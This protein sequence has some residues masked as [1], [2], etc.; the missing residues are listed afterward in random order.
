MDEKGMQNPIFRI[1]S[2]NN[3]QSNKN[4]NM[5]NMENTIDQNMNIQNYFSMDTIMMNQNSFSMDNPMMNQNMNMNQGNMMINQM[6]NQNM[7]MMNDNQRNMMNMNQLYMIQNMKGQMLMDNTIY[8]GKNDINSSQ[9]EPNIGGITVIFRTSGLGSENKSFY[10][11]TE[12]YEKV[13]ELIERYRIKSQDNCMTKKFIF[14]AKKLDFSLTVIEAGL[15][16]NAN[17]FVVQTDGIKG[18]GG[19]WY[20]KEIN[21]KFIKSS[22]IYDNKISNCQLNGLLKLCL[23]KEISSKLNDDE[24]IKLPEMIRCIMRILK[25]GYIETEEDIKE[26]IKKVLLKVKG[27]NI[28][29]FSE[30]VDETIDTNQI[31]KMIKLLDSND[32]KEINDIRFRLSKYNKYMEIFMK[33]FNKTKKESIFEFSVISLVVLERE[34]FE[35]FEKEREKCPNR[36]DKILYHGTSVVPIS[37]ILTE[38]F[39]KSVDRCYQH[40]KGVY[41]TDFLD[42]C[43]F[44]GGEE[45]NRANKNIIPGI[46]DVFTLIACSIYYNKK[47]FK[48]VTN[49]KYTPKKNEIN[50][51]Y[52]GAHFE[53][54][55]K[56]DF[57]KFVGTE[58]VIWDLDQICPFISAKLKRTDYCV[59]WRDNNFSSNPVYNNKFDEIF[60]KFLNERMK[61]IKQMAKY[62]IYPCETSEEALKLVERKKYNKIILISNVGTDLGGKK[63]VEKARKIIGNDIIALFLAYNIAH[64]KWIK[65]YKNALFSNDPKFYEEYLQCFEEKYSIKTNL[66]SLKNKM[67]EHYEVKFNFDDKFLDYPQFKDGGNYSDLSFNN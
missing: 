41:F 59:I 54:V 20:N 42:Y 15:T 17:I 66:E 56:P 38:Q 25:K 49:S 44:Y 28:I 12:P 51:A 60:K 53:T 35:K 33:E 22:K 18:A 40:G 30:Y 3:E 57:N 52:A 61:Y 14:N 58:Y 1:V 8:N 13:Y 32:L 55:I 37:C 19:S 24:L 63:F 5:E 21:I 46:D 34:D 43:W 50:F 6:M 2:N 7:N 26:T 62:N 67:E 29:N 47:G 36:V 23:L 48:T 45:S 16:N 39:K 65:D 4:Q 27:S 11:Q 64:L 9:N 10:L 31:N